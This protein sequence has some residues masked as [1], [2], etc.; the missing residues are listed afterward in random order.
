[1]Q[2]M[3]EAPKR[4]ALGK[5]LESLLPRVPTVAAPAA[6]EPSEAEHAAPLTSHEHEESAEGAEEPG[7]K[8]WRGRRR[9]R[10][11]RSSNVAAAPA[12]ES[13]EFLD[14]TANEGVTPEPEMAHEIQAAAAPRGRRS[15]QAPEK[16]VLPG[17]SLSKYGGTPAETAKS[18]EAPAPPRPASTY[19]PATLI[20]SPIVWDGSGLLPGESL[21]RHRGSRAEEPAAPVETAKAAGSADEIEE[22][23]FVE[24]VQQDQSTEPESHHNSTQFASTL[25][26][27]D[28][29]EETYDAGSTGY[30]P[31]AV[32]GE[33]STECE[34]G[35]SVEPELGTASEPQVGFAS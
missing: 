29:V 10:G 31:H 2:T 32:A 12:G 27:D 30:E 33:P 28:V 16:F 9:R 34:L 17:E 25:A 7:A 14:T 3:T 11:G 20:E 35:E 24:E 15:E 13:E 18:A 26:D 19:K 21:S 23:E 8:R 4:R 1:M 6:V 5:G 22:Q